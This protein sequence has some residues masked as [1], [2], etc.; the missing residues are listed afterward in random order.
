MIILAS[1]VSVS[2]GVTQNIKRKKLG[3]FS[4]SFILF[5]LFP[6]ISPM[7]STTTDAVF[8]APFKKYWHW[9]MW[10]GQNADALPAY[11]SEDKLRNGHSINAQACVGKNA[12]SHNVV[13]LATNCNLDARSTK[14]KVSLFKAVDVLVAFHFIGL[15]FKV[16]FVTH[17]MGDPTP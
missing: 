17:H 7:K 3:T 14:R 6:Q 1:D 8:R 16:H 11:H 4:S 10:V 5:L 15:L 9:K 13:T 2:G 12:D